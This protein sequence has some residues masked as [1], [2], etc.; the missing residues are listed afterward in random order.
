MASFPSRI[1]LF[2]VA[3]LLAPA[4]KT[5]DAYY[6]EGAPNDNCLLVDADLRC[7]SSAECS[8]DRPVCDV[9]GSGICVQCT[10]AE[11]GA[12]SGPTPACRDNTC[13][14]CVAHA[15][16]DDSNV[17]LP[18]G[19]CAAPGQVAYVQSGGT[20]A[21]PC[22][23]GAPCGTLQQ[24]VDADR[25]YIKIAV[26]TVVGTDV[27]TIDGKAVTILADP[28]A[29]LDRTGDGR[30]LLV[31]ST[32]ANVSI[33]DLEIMGQTGPADEAIQ[34]EPNGGNPALS[35]V[36]AK[37][38]GNQG[39]GISS[40][41]GSLTISQSTISS[42]TG[43]GI[44]VAGTGAIFAIANNYIF[45]NGDQD[46]GTFG[47]VNLGVTTAGLSRFEFNTV[48]DN[49]AATGAIRGGGLVCDII[50]FAAP[51]NIIARNSVGGSTSAPT[52]QTLGACTYPTSRI[53]NDVS[54]FNFESSDNAPFSYKL[55][56]GSSVIDQATTP[57]AIDIDHDGDPRPQGQ[58]K[59][60][61]A[62]EHRP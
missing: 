25:P 56:A 53:Q 54:L 62:D 22:A 23:R 12:C 2:L 41:G 51:N 8:G 39:R 3:I 4:C 47:G 15:E 32:G 29:K 19:S 9:G 34:L 46:M 21:P 6:C 7:S 18:D 30:I 40:S 59:D 26:G 35:L 48:V 36:R 37:V 14:A 44:S 16:C 28:G 1:P 55:M 45:R 58:E 60:I 49:R 13:Q 57:S 33:Y 52:A 27:T 24:G 61:G 38:T 42:N 11:A 17:C 31:R 50:G 5:R 10:P 43:G 20:G